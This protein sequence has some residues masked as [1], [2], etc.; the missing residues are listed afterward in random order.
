MSYVIECEH[1]I[2]DYRLGQKTVHALRSA[3]LCVEE[4]EFVAIMGRSGCGKSTLLK[5]L[6]TQLRPD[7]GTYLLNG[8]DI[9]G[10]PEKEILR[11]RRQDIGY[12][13]QN[14]SLIPEYTVWE[15]ICMP[16]YLD[17]QTPDIEYIETMAEKF[18][19]TDKL[20]VMPDQLSG[21]EQQRTAILSFL[22]V[23]LN[24]VVMCA[25]YSYYHRQIEADLGGNFRMLWKVGFPNPGA[26]SILLFVFLFTLLTA[27]LPVIGKTKDN[28]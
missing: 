4:G 25:A 3:D 22:S 27:L 1:L 24:Y 16:L 9:T 28:L 23:A 18:G 19:M 20:D 5:I 13:F 17:R 14:F 21:G 7:S 8:R 26:M 12:V 6:G 11:I 15:N 2:K 10:L